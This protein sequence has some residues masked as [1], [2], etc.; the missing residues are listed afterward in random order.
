MY[1][2]PAVRTIACQSNQY[3]VGGAPP[4]LGM[5][6]ASLL[7][8]TD[9]QHGTLWI[10]FHRVGCFSSALFFC[11]PAMGPARKAA[12]EITEAGEQ[13][14][15]QVLNLSPVAPVSASAASPSQSAKPEPVQPS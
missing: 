5:E 7:G 11:P 13:A 14:L 3:F 15:A 12:P 8:S 9:R 6:F 2:S 10:V 1:I 4:T